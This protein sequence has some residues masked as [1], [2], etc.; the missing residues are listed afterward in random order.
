MALHAFMLS[1]SFMSNI[2]VTPWT[3][4]HQAPLSIE[5]SRQEYW[6]RLPFLTQVIFLTHGSNPLLLGLLHWQVDSLT[7]HHL[8]SPSEILCV[9]QSLFV[10]PWTVDHWTCLPMEFSR[11]EYWS[12]LLLKKKKKKK[13]CCCCCR[14]VAQSCQNLCNSMDCSRPGFPVLHHL[15]GFLQLMSVESMMPSYHLIL[16]HLLLLLPTI[17][18]SIGVFPI[19]SDLH[20]MWS[21]Y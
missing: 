14:S 19:K 9:C 10:T 2:F 1:H 12:G 7:L 11:Q 21:K 13:N 5:L 3:I 17:F 20:I 4:A 16:C 8:G 18:S 15:P 6:S